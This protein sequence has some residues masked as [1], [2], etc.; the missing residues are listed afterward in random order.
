MLVAVYSAVA[1]PSEIA[2]VGCFL[3]MMI[4]MCYRRLTWVALGGFPQHLPHHLLHRLDP[5]CRAAASVYV[6]SYLQLPQQLSESLVNQ[7]ASPYLVIVGIDIILI[8]LGCIMDPAGILLV[9]IP[10]FVPII[11]ALGFDPVWFGVMF[12]VNIG[13]DQVAA[14]AGPEPV[15]H[16]E[17]RA[18]PR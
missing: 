14:T 1:T 7:S 11:K 9:T 10:I 4:T 16:Q 5:R 6:L 15:H 13:A 3:A 8:F 17:H 18:A 2:G 12:V